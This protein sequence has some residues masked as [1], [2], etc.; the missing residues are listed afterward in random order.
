MASAL[1]YGA[2]TT[3]RNQKDTEVILK[4][5]DFHKNERFF[6][7][8]LLTKIAKEATKS[9]LRLKIHMYQVNLLKTKGMIKYLISFKRNKSLNKWLETN[10]FSNNLF[11][12]LLVTLNNTKL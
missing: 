7:N 3:T 8:D 12:K 5:F 1:V 9:I 2:E 4:Y 10:N 6:F 11:E